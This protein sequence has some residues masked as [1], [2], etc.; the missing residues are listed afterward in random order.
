M[1]PWKA[2]IRFPIRHNWTFSLVLTVEALQ[3]KTCQDSLLSGEGRSLGAKISG[4]MGSPWGIFFGFYKTRHIL[5]SDS[6]NCIVLRAV[7]LTQY[8]RVTDGRTEGRN[9]RTALAM[10]RAVK[11]LNFR[12]SYFTSLISSPLVTWTIALYNVGATPGWYFQWLFYVSIA[13]P[14]LYVYNVGLVDLS[15]KFSVFHYKEDF[16][17]LVEFL[18]LF[19]APFPGLPYLLFYMVPKQ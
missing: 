17:V 3:G 10:R 12:R 2:R 1:T 16:S 6:A 13:Y 7:L 15:C 4:G 8:R 9:C 11:K 18:L 19:S 14:L 5:L